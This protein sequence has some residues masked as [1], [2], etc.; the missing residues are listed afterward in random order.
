MGYVNKGLKLLGSKPMV[1]Y[2]IET[3][4]RQTDEILI[5]A[6][7]DI[8]NYQDKGY[9]V[10]SDQFTDYAGPLAGIHAG[11]NACGTKYLLC[12]PCDSPFIPHDLADRLA[13]AIAESHAQ[14]ALVTCRDLEATDTSKPPPICAQP[15]FALI[16]KELCSDLGEFLRIGGRKIMQWYARHQVVEVYFENATAFA[17]INCPEQLLQA[18]AQLH[19]K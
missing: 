9:Q 11:L 14:I 13:R 6:N 19:T 17:N 4:R 10:I 7:R 2:V 12:C 5:N 8:E 1:D 16:P 3:L 18:E 15:V